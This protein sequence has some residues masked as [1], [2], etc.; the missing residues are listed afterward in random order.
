MNPNAIALCLMKNDKFK[1]PSQ[2]NI[3]LNS[4]SVDQDFSSN[5]VM[6]TCTQSSFYTLIKVLR[7]V[8]DTFL[9]LPIHKEASK[10]V[11]YGES[12]TCTQAE[13]TS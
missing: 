2:L 3:E 13:H 6:T 9:K 4:K 10:S 11:K 1:Q 7:M 5:E 12:D 8:A